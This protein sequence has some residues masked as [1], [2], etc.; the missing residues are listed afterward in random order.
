MLN[1]QGSPTKTVVQLV[2]TIEELRTV[3]ASLQVPPEVVELEVLMRRKY[4]T[5]EEVEKLYPLKASSLKK[6]RT[7]GKGPEYIRDGERVLYT[8]EAIQKY[9]EA[10]R[11]KTLNRP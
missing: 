3:M 11:Q 6:M 1:Q 10:G 2:T 9:L 5:T 8:H 7:D 4:L